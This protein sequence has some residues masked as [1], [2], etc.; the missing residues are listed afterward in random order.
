MTT[1]HIPDPI[2][3]GESRAEAAYD[4]MVKSD[5]KWKCDCGRI[6]DPKLEGENFIS[7]DPYAMPVCGQC[8]MN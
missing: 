6:F 5:G 8:A 4:E 3:R 7:P 2:E 1:I